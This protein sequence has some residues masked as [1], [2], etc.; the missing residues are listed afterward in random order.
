M[1]HSWTALAVSAVH[2]KEKLS[3]DRSR[4]RRYSRHQASKEVGSAGQVCTDL[5]VAE[6]KR[7]RPRRSRSYIRWLSPITVAR[8]TATVQPE[9]SKTERVSQPCGINEVFENESACI[10][11]AWVIT[12]SAWGETNTC[13]TTRLVLKTYFTVGGLANICNASEHENEDGH[14]VKML[15]QA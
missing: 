10:R 6:D 11:T 3:L 12:A 13:K 2:F 4:W 7:Q 14:D 15:K 8:T 9:L 1:I 5:E